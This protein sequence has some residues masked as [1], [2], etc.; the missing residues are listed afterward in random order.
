MEVYEK[1]VMEVVELEDKG[2]VVMTATNVGFPGFGG[3]GDAN[4]SC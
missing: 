3:T 2:T 1:P 4:A